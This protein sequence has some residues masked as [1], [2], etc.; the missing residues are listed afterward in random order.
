MEPET[1]YQT[2]RIDHHGIVAGICQEIRLIE[3]IDRQVGSSEQK[4]SCGQGTQAMVLNALG[5]SSRAL[6]L[7]PDFMHNK[8]VDVLIGPG[9]VAEDFNDDS[10]GRSLDALYAREVTEV[11]AQVAARALRVYGIEHR[12]VHVD[13][14]LFHLHGQY[15]MEEPDKEAITITEGYSRDHRPDLKQVVVQL[16]TSQR[17]SLPVWLEVLSGNSSDKESFPL[18]VEAYNQQIGESEAPYYVMD[19]AGYAADNLKTLKNMCWLMRVPETLA[20]AKR[21]V[22]E[23][24]KIEMTS[25]TEGYWGKEVKPTYGEVEQRWLVVFSQAAYDRELH[26]LTKNQEKERLAAGK[27]WHKLSLQTFN[28]QEDAQTAAKQFNQGWKFHQ[29]VAEVAAI[30]HY[31]KPG[32]PS[33]EDEPEIVGY[34]LKGSLSGASDR[35]EAAKR[36][37]GKF[38]IATNELDGLKLSAVQMLSNYTDQG[39]SVER[40][41]RFLKDPLFFADSLFLKKPERIMALIMGLALLIYALAERQLRLA[42]ETN[43][44]KIPDQKG[45]PTSTPTIR[46][47]FQTFEGI[48]IL[49]IWVNGQ[50]TSR[51]VLNLRPVHEQIVRLFG[52]QVRN[53][54]F[55]DA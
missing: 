21:L 1:K 14:S 6:Y 15:E 12:F 47:V 24:E 20:E 30:T 45:K 40:G 52:I 7:M 34:G 42:L 50:R 53:C 39:I 28:C 41:F 25:L 5:F 44:E 46:W 18:S 33:A 2:D 43:N 8:P 13:S 48:D 37:L 9:L 27:Q 26:T 23:S 19:S 22:R 36:N 49:S 11:F 29:A 10:L 55:L 38:I 17:S 51:Q 3:E 16:I 32:R 4:V 31:A 35:V 54:Y